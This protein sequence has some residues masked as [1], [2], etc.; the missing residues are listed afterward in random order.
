MLNEAPYIRPFSCPSSCSGVARIQFSQRAV[1]VLQKRIPNPIELH[2][3]K[4]IH[5]NFFQAISSIKKLR[6][7]C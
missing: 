4:A 5:D 2:T 7:D 1:E 6:Y 3:V